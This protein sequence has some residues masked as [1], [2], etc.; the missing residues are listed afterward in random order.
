MRILAWTAGLGIAGGC[1]LLLALLTTA[2]TKVTQPEFVPGQHIVIHAGPVT[3][4]GIV[5]GPVRE[6]IAKK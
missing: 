1:A 5:D 6:I 4:E 2:P 3:I